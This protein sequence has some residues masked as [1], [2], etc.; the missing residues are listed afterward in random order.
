[1]MMHGTMN[2]KIFTVSLQFTDHETIPGMDGVGGPFKY[3]LQGHANCRGN[4]YTA[5]GTSDRRLY[6]RHTN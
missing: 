6:C 1:M 5:I 2:V 4:C 3:S